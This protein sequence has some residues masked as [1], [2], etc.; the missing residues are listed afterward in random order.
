MLFSYHLPK[1]FIVLAKGI[2]EFSIIIHGIVDG[3]DTI[4]FHF[5]NIGI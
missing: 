3:F 4:D 5:E 1:P 2:I